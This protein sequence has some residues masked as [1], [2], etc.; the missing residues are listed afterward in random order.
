MR[1]ALLIVC[2][3]CS[4]QSAPD[5][6][7]GGY[8]LQALDEGRAITLVSVTPYNEVRLFPDSPLE[9]ERNRFFLVGDRVIDRFGSEQVAC[10]D[11]K[12]FVSGRE[13]ARL[14]ATG[15]DS[16]TVTIVIEPDGTA[17]VTHPRDPVVSKMRYRGLRKSD[18]CRAALLFYMIPVPRAG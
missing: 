2:V 13:E 11:A 10:R 18:S 6:G 5:T 8:E 14:T 3:A 1:R 15:L 9:A 4:S 17:A 16:P 7:P 12:V